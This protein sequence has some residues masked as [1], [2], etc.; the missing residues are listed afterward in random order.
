M[1]FKKLLLSTSLIAIATYAQ[2]DITIGVVTSSSGPVAMVGIPQ[3]NTVA[4]LP[5]KIGNENVRYISLDDASDPT[6]SVKAVEKLIKENKVDAIIGPSGSP[7]AS[8][9]IGTIA[10]AKVPLLAPVGTSSIVMPMTDQKKWVFKT[11]QNDEIIAE[12]LVQD[13]VKRKITTLGFIGTAD[14][15]GENWGKVLANLAKKNGIKI[16]AQESFQRQDTSLTGQALK[17]ISKKPQAILVAAPGSSAVPPQTALYD[18]G[19]RGQIYQTH[20]AALDQYLKMGGKKV[21]NTILAASLMLVLNEVSN[22]HPSK[23]IATKYINDYKAKYKQTPA[24]FGAN[25]YDA[26]ILLE[27]AVP[28]ALKKAKPGTVQFREA[29]RDA[30]ESTKE[31]AGTQGVYNMSPSDHSGFDKRGREMIIVKNGQWK[32]LK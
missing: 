19:Y 30:L 22:T 18:R 24:T 16:V 21:E 27:K 23:K 31:V 28:T 3:K 1:M 6:A 15:Y 25:V 17:L 12:A 9:V 4:L 7:N 5:K 14:P 20:G 29:L 8:A 2:A 13:M 10:K 11:T 26:G 32:L